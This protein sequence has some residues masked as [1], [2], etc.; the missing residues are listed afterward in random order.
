MLVLRRTDGNQTAFAFLQLLKAGM[1]EYPEA[2]KVTVFDEV[3]GYPAWNE[4]LPHV[5]G[6]Y[7]GVAPKSVSYTHLTLPTN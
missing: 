3:V 2:L 7:H 1:D 6:A 4:T 5:L